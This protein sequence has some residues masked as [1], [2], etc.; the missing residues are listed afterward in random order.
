MQGARTWF[1][2]FGLSLRSGL[3][4]EQRKN[5]KGG[6]DEAIRPRNGRRITSI[7]CSRAAYAGK[8][9]PSPELW[10]NGN[11][12]WEMVWFSLF[13]RRKA[14]FSLSPVHHAPP[15]A[16][17]FSTAVLIFQIVGVFPNVQPDHRKFA[18][19]DRAI[20]IGG[21]CDFELVR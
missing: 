14:P 20:L 3:T 10:E 16:D 5:Q 15:G 21:R 1:R 2:A 17:V 4:P 6:F 12:P 8:A 19:H 9:D 11:I 13:S 18:L 7:P